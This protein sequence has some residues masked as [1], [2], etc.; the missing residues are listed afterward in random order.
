MSPDTD[1]KKQE[2]NGL[3]HLRCMHF[4]SGHTKTTFLQSYTLWSGPWTTPSQKGQLSLLFQTYQIYRKIPSEDFHHLPLTYVQQYLNDT[5]VG[6][7]PNAII[8]RKRPMS[9][10][11]RFSALA[12]A[13]AS[14]RFQQRGIG[15]AWIRAEGNWGAGA[16]FKAGQSPAPRAELEGICCMCQMS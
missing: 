5:S 11:K 4:L 14:S 1:L 13:A 8:T 16:G 15:R 7:V 12:Y 6:Q 3:S 9:P 2:H 10:H